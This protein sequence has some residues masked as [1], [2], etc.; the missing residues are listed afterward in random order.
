[1]SD[2]T[3]LLGGLC[4]LLIFQISTAFV[5]PT[6]MLSTAHGYHGYVSINKFPLGKSML[7]NSC[8]ALGSSRVSAPPMQLHMAL[9]NAAKIGKLIPGNWKA[10]LLSFTI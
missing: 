1:M 9:K 6:N 5:Q 7:A 3:L 4:A 8:R 2:G 10:S